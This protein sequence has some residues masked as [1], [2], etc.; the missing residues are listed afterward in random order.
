MLYVVLLLILFLQGITMSNVSDLAAQ[1]VDIDADIDSL[2][3]VILEL[4]AQVANSPVTQE[5]LDALV[6]QAQ[7][8]NAKS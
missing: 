7:A 4:Q 1:L 5:Q 3:A 6:A 2:L 8:I